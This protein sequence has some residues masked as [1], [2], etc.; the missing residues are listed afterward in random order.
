MDLAALPSDP[1][2][3]PGWPD[4]LLGHDPSRRRWLRRMLAAD[5]LWLAVDSLRLLAALQ[6]GDGLTA[7]LALI[8]LDL[9]LMA[10]FYLLVRQG[11]SADLED[12]ALTWPQVLAALGSLLLSYALIGVGRGAAVPLLCLVLVVGM[13]QLPP[14]SL[15]LPGGLALGLMALC[16]LGWHL[17]GGDAAPGGLQPALGLMVAAAALLPVLWSLARRAADLRDEHSGQREA[18][19]QAVARLE[20]LATRDTLTG[21]TN[22]RHM[23][24]LLEAE[25]K[26]HARGGRAFCVAMID[27]DHFKRLN[28]EQGRERGDEILKRLA[29]LSQ[30]HLRASDVVARWGGE[31]FLILMPET[32]LAGSLRSLERWREHLFTRLGFYRAGKWVPVSSSAGVTRYRDGETIHQ[33]LARVEQSLQAAKANGRDQVIS[34]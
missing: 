6:Q 1:P 27:I 9:A 10:A 25:C 23:L 13:H 31:E 21:L 4:W 29:S 22:H 33:T 30:A 20:S 5:A 3:A 28:E 15:I 32:D 14:R 12:P 8:G 11:A 7:P 34:A 16:A 18:L 19:L 24:T 26:R 2:Q 17:L